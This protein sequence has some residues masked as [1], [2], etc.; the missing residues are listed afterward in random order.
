MQTHRQK[1]E[2]H[3]NSQTEKNRHN[4]AIV[5]PSFPFQKFKL[6]P[7]IGLFAA[8]RDI[9]HKFLFDPLMERFLAFFALQAFYIQ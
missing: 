5:Y 4:N 3:H 8:S 7:S 2:M 6:C 1:R 9:V